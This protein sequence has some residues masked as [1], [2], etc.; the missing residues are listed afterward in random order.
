MNRREMIA[1]SVV[2]AVGLALPLSPAAEPTRELSVGVLLADAVSKNNLVS[3]FEV[4]R[5]AMPRL[6]PCPVRL[7]EDGGKEIGRVVG[8]SLR[9]KWLFADL[10]IPASLWRKVRDG[11]LVCRPAVCGGWDSESRPRRM[12]QLERVA[13]VYLEV[14]TKQS[15]V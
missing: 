8:W 1:S 11:R 14:P 15:W 3:P 5:D 4:I 9:G 6:G 10:Q 7:G 2:G 13:Y 12:L